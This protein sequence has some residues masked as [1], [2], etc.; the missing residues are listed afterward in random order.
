MTD[1]RLELERLS[2]VGSRY[3]ERMVARPAIGIE[4]RPDGS[5]NDRGD[6]PNYGRWGFGGQTRQLGG[7]ILVAATAQLLSPESPSRRH[8]FIVNLD[9]TEALWVQ[10][11]NREP[12]GVGLPGQRPLNPAA[13]ANT[14]GG[15]LDY[16]GSVCPI[17]AVWI[18]ATT[19]GHRFTAYEM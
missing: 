1:P 13:A 18:I 8:L 14:G 3:P 12:T 17:D 5:G 6:S 2:P 16:V 7:Q 10:F 19:A 15:V 9:T 4:N 11:G